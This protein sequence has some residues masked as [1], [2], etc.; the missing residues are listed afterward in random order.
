MGWWDEGGLTLGDEPIDRLADA[1]ESIRDTYVAN[2]GREP[3]ADELA[4][5]AEVALRNVLD[6]ASP[7]ARVEVE[8]K[9]KAKPAKKQ[10]AEVGDVFVIRLDKCHYG[11]IVFR[12]NSGTLIELYK[13]TS[14][15]PR[16]VTRVDCSPA[17]IKHHKWVLHS[18][19]FEPFRWKVIGSVPVPADYHY[20]SFLYGEKD[21]MYAVNAA[22]PN[23]KSYPTH[24]E[25]L[26]QRLETHVLLSPDDIEANLKAGRKDYWP[27]VIES[28]RGRGVKV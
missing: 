10:K 19:T 2:V 25:F 27:E 7:N 26:A 15:R 12:D 21:L 28:L 8:V 1:L 9:V 16:P 11:R 3:T 17:N 5:A 20:P 22:D 24:K 18:Q 13:E 14:D 4:R 6:A 23:D